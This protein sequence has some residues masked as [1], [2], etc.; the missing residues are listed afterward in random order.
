M[1]VSRE[2][3]CSTIWAG[4]SSQLEPERLE[5]LERLIAQTLRLHA[6][7]SGRYRGVSSTD[8]QPRARRAGWERPLRQESASKPA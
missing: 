4:Y 6:E 2:N 5:I 7:M 3:I 8:F 1:D